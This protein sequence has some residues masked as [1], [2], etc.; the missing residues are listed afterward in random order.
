MGKLRRNAGALLDL[1][2]V[3]G[4][5]D[6]EGDSEYDEYETDESGDWEEEGAS[7]SGAS[8]DETAGTEEGIGQANPLGT[9]G[10]FEHTALD[11]AHICLS[12][13]VFVRTRVLVSLPL[14][15]EHIISSQ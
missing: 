4:S 6:E 15:L 12:W 14:S 10:K 11:C 7:A 9:S 8:E 13:D 3:V 2:P 1:D 5:S